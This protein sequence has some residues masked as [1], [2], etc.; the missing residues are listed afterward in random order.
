MEKRYYTQKEVADLVGVNP[1]IITYWEEQLKIFR[2]QKR[3]GR[4]LFTSKDLKKALLVKQLLDSGLSLKGVKNKLEEGTID[5]MFPEVSKQILEEIRDSLT[6]ALE[7]IENLRRHIRE[8]S[9]NWN[10]S[11]NY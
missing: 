4:K 7:E 2:P 6:K 9:S 5:E 10:N 3:G 8:R 1:G 11:G